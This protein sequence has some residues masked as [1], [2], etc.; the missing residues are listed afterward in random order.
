[1]VLT[2]HTKGVDGQIIVCNHAA[3]QATPPPIVAHNLGSSR[4]TFGQFRSTDFGV[5]KKKINRASC[6]P[7]QPP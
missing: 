5:R 2:C 6:L 3:N 1:M 7:S 4:Q